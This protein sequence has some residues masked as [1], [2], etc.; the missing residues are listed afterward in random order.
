M[1]QPGEQAGRN[2]EAVD[3]KQLLDSST[4]HASL[5]DAALH[6]GQSPALAPIY[7]ESSGITMG[8]YMKH[9]KSQL[10]C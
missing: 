9:T 8:Y 5:T 1:I 2:E 10:L 3:A 6:N 4:L 7:I